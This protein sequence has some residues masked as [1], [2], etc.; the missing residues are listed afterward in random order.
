MTTTDRGAVRLPAA[1]EELL[2]KQAITEVLARYARGID[3][4]DPE[5][6]ASCYHPE[7]VDSHGPWEGTGHDFARRPARS[8]PEN[9]AN[10]HAQC[11]TLIE[12]DGDTALV[13]T[14]F[15]YHRIY[16]TTEG[17]DRLQEGFGRY[18]DRFA[19]RAGVWRILARKVVM[20]VTREGPVTEEV[21]TAH[22]FEQGQ[23]YPDD[24][25]YHPERLPREQR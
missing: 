13:E 17:A 4:V 9:K 6:I 20:D 12:L 21:V 14:Y 24:L 11:Q 8:A 23:R 2:D 15:S 10:H 18:V 7:A 22:H 5:L 1:V 25:V 3:R 16:T 19:K